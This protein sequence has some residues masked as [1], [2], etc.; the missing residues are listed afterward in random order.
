MQWDDPELLK[1]IQESGMGVHIGPQHGW[2]SGVREGETVQM[3]GVPVR[4]MR[5]LRLAS[6]AQVPE[7]HLKRAVSCPDVSTAAAY[8]VYVAIFIRA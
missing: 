1:R 8:G 4:V 6:L 2:R 7:V 3:N 5:V